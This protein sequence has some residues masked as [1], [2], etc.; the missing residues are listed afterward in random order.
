MHEGQQLYIISEEIQVRKCALPKEICAF[1]IWKQIKG[2]LAIS[3]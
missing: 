1:H 2:G 3:K